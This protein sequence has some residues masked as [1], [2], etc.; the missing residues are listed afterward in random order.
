MN[1]KY[2]E[3]WHQLEDLK[4]VQISDDITRISVD[5]RDFAVIFGTDPV[6]LERDPYDKPIHQRFHAYSLLDDSNCKDH[7]KVHKN[8]IIQFLEDFKEYTGGSVDWRTFTVEGYR[9]VTGW[10]FKYLRFYRY[11]ID[12]DY[13]ILCSDAL[14]AVNKDLITRKNIKVYGN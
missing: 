10:D 9:E 2:L 13:F 5:T 12:P 1:K 3:D 14:K 4:S 6:T 11:K 8:D 7:F